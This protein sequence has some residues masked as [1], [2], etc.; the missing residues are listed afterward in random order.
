MKQAQR[1]LTV[2][3]GMVLILAGNMLPIAAAAT[4]RPEVRALWVD[5]FHDG[6]KNPAQ[7]DRLIK[8]AVTGNINTLIVQVR[9][10]G[11]AYYHRSIEPRTEDPTLQPGFDAL[12][13]LIE[14]AH[15]NR[16]EVHAWLNTLVAWNRATAPLDPK[17]VWNAHG[18]TAIGRANWISYYRAF[19]K[20]KQVWS[21]KLQSSYYL[22]PGHPDLVDY[23]VAVYLEVVKN[24]DVD[25]IHLDYSRYAG[26]EWGYNPTSLARY[27]ARY[28]T[29]GLP[30][31]DDPQWAAWRREQTANLVR[32]VYLQAIALKPKVK[33]SSA[34]I[35]W[36]DGP[37]TAADWE[38]SRAYTEVFQDWR[39]WLQEGILD[40][41]M[42]MNYF[43]DFHPTQQLW[44]NRWI[45]WEKDHQYGRQIVIGPGS[46][47]Q[48]IEDTLYQIRRAQSP[49]NLGNYAAGVSLY[50]YGSSHLYSNDDYAGGA[51][52]ATLPRQPH[53]YLP[54]S[55]DLLFATLSQ[56][57]GYWDPVFDTFIPTR[58]VFPAPAAIPEQPWKIRPQTGFLM[59]VVSAEGKPVD[60][61]RITVEPVR[62]LFKKQPRRLTVTDGNGWFGLAELPPGRYRVSVR[63]GGLFGARNGEVQIQPGR[64]SN[65]RL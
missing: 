39:G 58:P 48:Y 49:S 2:L 18:P 63:L 6:I 30:A 38:R 15:A 46:Y 27:Q 35:T 10:R 28:G 4:G 33:V 34:V 26:K 7:V 9:R 43:R 54:E 62:T 21:D 25:G 29:T 47:M 14:Q 5:A 52:A 61:L 20:D 59:G 65:I 13:Y 1:N 23:T 42:P 3:L 8:D 57:G 11:D 36:G 56:T 60:H 37:V 45:E 16:I 55:N 24:Y 41:A 40:L 22:D 50:T 19:D 17:H 53:R 12:Q 44:Y 32:K 64:V 31:P 51:P